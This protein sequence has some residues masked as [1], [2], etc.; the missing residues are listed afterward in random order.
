MPPE[1]ITASTSNC[2]RRTWPRYGS[3]PPDPSGW[4]SRGQKSTVSSSSVPHSGQRLMKG[5][6]VS[7]RDTSSIDALTNEIGGGRLRRS[8]EIEGS[9]AGSYE[10]GD[11]G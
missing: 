10:G 3:G 8:P 5:D 9:N 1:P 2:P 4:P 7:T 6:R 11:V